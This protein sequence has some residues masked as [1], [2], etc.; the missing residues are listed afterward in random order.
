MLQSAF[1]FPNVTKMK[2]YFFKKLIS[3]HP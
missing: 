3:K 2:V 1:D